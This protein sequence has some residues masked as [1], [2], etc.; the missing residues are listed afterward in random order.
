VTTD[1]IED[2]YPL[3]VTQ[4]GMLLHALSRPQSGTFTEQLCWTLAGELRP[5]VLRRAWQVLIARET[6]LRAEVVWEGM[7][8]P[9]LVIRGEADL[10]WTE[11]DGSDRPAASLPAQLDELAGQER[12]RPFDVT[13]GPLMRL[14]VVRL[15]GDR[16]RILWTFHHLLIDGWSLALLVD[17]L[18]ETYRCLAAGEPVPARRRPPFRE[19][20][21]W[22]Q[23]R[24][25]DAARD[26][27]RRALSGLGEPTPL[28]IDEVGPS[29][30]RHVERYGEAELALPAGA[31]AALVERLRARRVTLNTAVEAAWARLWSAYTGR[32]EVVF[33]VTT[34]GRSGGL[35]GIESMIGMFINALPVHT[36]VPVDLPVWQWL[37]AFQQA[38]L[39]RQDHEWLPLV[40]IRDCAEL[41]AGEPLFETALVFENYPLDPA[42]WRWGS[43][44]TA[45]ELS[46][47]GGRANHPLTLF[48]FPGEQL[49]FRAVF[50]A[51]RLPSDRVAALLRHLARLL[52]A[53]AG[54]RDTTVGQWSPLDDGELRR[55][56]SPPRPRPPEP[57]PATA[58]ERFAAMARERPDALAAVPVSGASGA[59]TYRELQRRVRRLAAL[60]KQP[61]KEPQP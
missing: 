32:D 14:V 15:P 34:S 60:L 51:R 43:R 48:I 35:P 53:I 49:M 22:L 47:V 5:D 4:Q 20:V 3:T 1:D 37:G 21:A 24:D 44:T 17:Q 18:A 57:R 30:D 26:H 41:A 42:R 56:T 52:T 9:M 54:G 2:I 58:P 36:A 33:G 59:V 55:L 46:Y 25:V 38:Q 45:G 12:L 61:S 6:L 31:T 29:E 11:V 10:P 50:D 27:W 40:H 16:H 28:G 8:E 7:P 39:G 23:M 19:Y 13:R